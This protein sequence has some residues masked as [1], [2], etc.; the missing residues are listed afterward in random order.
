MR[1]REVVADQVVLEPEGRQR[2]RQRH[3]RRQHHH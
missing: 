2:G 1:R 3:R